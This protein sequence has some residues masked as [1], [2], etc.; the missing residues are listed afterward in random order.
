MER[1]F[2]EVFV[3]F[4]L[5]AA[6]TKEEI[7]EMYVNTIY[8]GSGYYGICAAAEGYYGCEPSELT[9]YQAVMLAGLPNAPSSL[10]AGRQSGACFPADGAGTGPDGGV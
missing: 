4:D 10:F 5:E 1:K 9:D 6:Y 7:F 3:A 2:A 8:F